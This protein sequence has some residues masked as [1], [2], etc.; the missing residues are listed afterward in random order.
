MCPAI[1]HLWFCIALTKLCI[2]VICDALD[3]IPLKISVVLNKMPYHDYHNIL[4]K[5][6]VYFPARSLWRAMQRW[7]F[8]CRV[9]SPGWSKNFRWFG[10]CIALDYLMAHH[11]YHGIDSRT[12][13]DTW[14]HLWHLWFSGDTIPTVFRET[15]CRA[16]VTVSAL[17]AVRTAHWL[18]KPELNLL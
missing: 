9:S 14:H 18:P 17:G 8:L 6:L 7:T 16:Q 1:P 5:L 13:D 11:Q 2:S 15:A 4:L 10:L 3:A 12:H